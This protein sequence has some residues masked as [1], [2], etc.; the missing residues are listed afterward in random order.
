MSDCDVAAFVGCYTG[1]HTTQ[2]L[3]QSAV[4]AGA[5]VAIGF[6]TEIYCNQ[7]N[8]WV[9]AFAAYHSFGDSPE[10]AAYYAHNYV[11]IT[12]SIASMV[13]ITSSN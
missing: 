5:R 4:N 11:G 3:P 1:N 6:E 13:V 9:S 8:S 7:A 12:T 10:E 2:S